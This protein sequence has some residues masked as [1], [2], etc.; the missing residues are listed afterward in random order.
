[1]YANLTSRVVNTSRASVYDLMRA[2]A[3]PEAPGALLV[4]CHY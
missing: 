3:A 4:T 1:M 2:L